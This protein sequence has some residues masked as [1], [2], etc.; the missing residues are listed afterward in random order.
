MAKRENK[1][2]KNAWR[3]Q[4]WESTDALL[5]LVRALELDP[6]R[7]PV[8]FNFNTDDIDEREEMPFIGMG[9]YMVEWEDE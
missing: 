9:A 2:K 1:Q 8:R 4:R 7:I 6:D 3:K 5:R